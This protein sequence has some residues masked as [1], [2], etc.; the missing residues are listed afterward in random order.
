MLNNHTD[1]E[2]LEFYKKTSD[3]LYLGILLNRYRLLVFGVC[4]KYLKD[5]QN[6]EDASQ[7][8]FEKVISE[9]KKYNISYFKSWLYIV[10]KNQCLM[11]LRKSLNKPTFSYKEIDDRDMGIEEEQDILV[12]EFLYEKTISMLKEAMRKLSNEQELCIRL[13]YLEKLS[14]RE[15]ESKTGFTFQQIKSYIQNGKRN[16]NIL[17]KN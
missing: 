10:A 17:L 1:S 12:K 5:V 16:L 4:M 7:Q 11:Q 9:V 14:Y 8:V 2:L 13:F 15:I 3:S 6:A